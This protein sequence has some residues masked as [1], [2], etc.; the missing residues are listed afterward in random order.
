MCA[1]EAATQR[2]FATDPLNLTLTGPRVNRYQKAR[3][4]RR[5]GVAAGADR[6]RFAALVI[7]VPQRYGLTIDRREANALDHVPA[8]CTSTELGVFG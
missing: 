6:C 7:T 4:P 2:R 8:G 1:N 5:C 3:Q